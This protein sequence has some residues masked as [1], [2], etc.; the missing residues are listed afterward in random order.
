MNK[1]T[2]YSNDV[3]SV[4]SYFVVFTFYTIGL[5]PAGC[6]FYYAAPSHIFKLYRVEQEEWTKLREGVPYV[7]LYRKNPK[8]LYPKL[9]GLGD[10]GN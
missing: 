2:R 4:D 6:Q 5:Q 3:D 1:I 8:H 7:K 10:N 9:N